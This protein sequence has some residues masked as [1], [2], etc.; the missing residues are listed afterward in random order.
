MTTQG[1]LG[2]GVADGSTVYPFNKIYTSGST[3]T[4]RRIPKP[5]AGASIYVSG[6]LQTTGYTIDTAA[7]TVT[8]GSAREPPPR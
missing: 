3:S 1:L 7:G 4:L 5:V 6:V 2:T 8:F